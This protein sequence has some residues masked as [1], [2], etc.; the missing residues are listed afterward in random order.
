MTEEKSAETLQNHRKREGSKKSNCQLNL[1]QNCMNIL[2]KEFY[3]RKTIVV[4]RDLLGK[5][6]I[7]EIGTQKITA[8]IV[9]TEAYAGLDDKASHAHKGRTP[10]NSIMFGP[11]GFAYVYFTYG[12]HHLFNIVTEEVNYPSAVL[13]RAVEPIS[14]LKFIQENRQGRKYH[15]LTSGP[16]KFTKA[17]RIDKCFNGVD[18][19]IGKSIWVEDGPAI[20]ENRIATT[21]RIG[22]GYSEECAKWPRRFFIK[23]NQFIS[24][25]S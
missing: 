1:V 21:P 11:A 17:F 23:D 16:A 2:P 13:I 4:A 10:R 7:R 8:R 15:E 5:V 20:S 14:G 19:T 9:E 25:K 12:L 18:I 22:V 24:A 3:E 6:I